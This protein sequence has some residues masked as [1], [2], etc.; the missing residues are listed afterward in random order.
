VKAATAGSRDVAL[1][2]VRDVFGREFRTAQAAFDYRVRRA[3]LSPRDRA[4]TAELAY[5]AIKM[6]RTLDWYLRPYVA[7]RAQPLP[8]AI[9]EALRLGAYQVLF[10][11]GVDRHA[12]V[13]ETVGA[14]LRV[15]HRGTAG[16]VNAVLRKL[17]ADAP[18]SPSP[19]DFESEDEYL[20]TRFSVPDWIAAQWRA[21]FGERALDALAGIGGAPQLGF[22]VNALRASVDDVIALLEERGVRVRRSELARDALVALARPDGAI[23]D[24]PEGRWSLQGEASCLPVDLLD[25]KPGER[26]VDLCSGRG[27]KAVQLAA[28]M[29]NAGSLTC[30]ELD[31]RRVD[32]LGQRLVRANVAIARVTAADARLAAPAEEPAD[33]VLVDAPCSA[34]GILGRHPEA[35]W[36]KRPDDAQRMA[37]DQSLLLASAASR[38]RADGRVAYAVCSTDARECEEVVAAFLDASPEFQRERLPERYASFATPAG[39]V[40]VPPGIDGRDGFFVALLRRRAAA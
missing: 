34:L 20:G 32:V 11:G 1:A 8:A 5:G 30:V 37:A 4:F 40:L 23:D 13:F 22:R 31:Q 7:A 25:P 38:L 9:A 16:L 24:D 33:A 14:A 35:R 6:R 15:G 17:I 36:R 29:E 27:N 18:P 26:V 19:Q 39:D 2:I 21:R 10:M 28:R 12:A 3:A